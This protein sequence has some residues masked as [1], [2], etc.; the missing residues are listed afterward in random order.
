MDC[1]AT[2]AVAVAKSD[3]EVAMSTQPGRVS[4]RHRLT[5][6]KFEQFFHGRA[7]ATVAMEAC[8][9]LHF[10]DLT[11][12]GPSNVAFSC[13]RVPEYTLQKCPER[14]AAGA[15]CWTPGARRRRPTADSADGPMLRNHADKG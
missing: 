7:Q 12:S 15:R 8:G 1:S 14:P 10:C 4:E 6:T 5:R 9:R 2:I 13:G 11:H 3:F